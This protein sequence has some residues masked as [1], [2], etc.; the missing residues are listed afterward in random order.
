MER[1]NFK[2]FTSDGDWSKR[3]IIVIADNP[4]EAS[5][6]VEETLI[7]RGKKPPFLYRWKYA[8]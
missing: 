5:K 1:Y 8:K 4:K 6:K 2:Y 3:G 7:N